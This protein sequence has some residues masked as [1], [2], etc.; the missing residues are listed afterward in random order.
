ML[1]RDGV[2]DKAAIIDVLE[3]AAKVFKVSAREI[4]EACDATR[5]NTINASLSWFT[6]IDHARAS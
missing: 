2:A 3:S 5:S 1:V 4:N 6:P